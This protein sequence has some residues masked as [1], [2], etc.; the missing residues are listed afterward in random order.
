MTAE[1]LLFLHLSDIHFHRRSGKPGDLDDDLRRQLEHDAATVRKGLPGFT[2]IL[3]SGDIAYSGQQKEYEIAKAWLTKLCGTLG[4]KPE[5]V[6]TVPGNHDVDRGVVKK[7]WLIQGMHARLRTPDPTGVDREMA[8]MLSDAK[9]F[10]AL[11]EPLAEYNRFAHSYECQA[12]VG[13][14]LQWDSDL[15]LNDGSVLRLRGANS[16]LISGSGEDDAGNRLVVGTQQS[17]PPASAG[18]THLLLCHHPP[19][20]LWE[21]DQFEDNLKARVAVA[22]FGH[23]HVQRVTKVD[24]SLRVFSGAVQ[25]SRGESGWSPRYNFLALTVDGTGS[26]RTLR[27]DLMPR[28][29]HDQHKEFRADRGRDGHDTVTYSLNL[30]AWAPVAVGPPKAD[31]TGP[32]PED[33]RVMNPE[34]RLTFRFFDLPYSSRM[35]VVQ[36]LGLIEDED[37]GVREADRY[38]RYFERAHERNLLAQLWQEVESRQADGRPDENPFTQPK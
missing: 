21:R 14:Q 22:L 11:H 13:G 18:V 23:K 2:G 30:P 24:N 28:V 25:P 10:E 19:D 8:D 6:W 32:R 36:K 9:A 34:R 4:C 33:G 1:S 3:V 17:L 31:L 12:G 37:E 16:A 26:G 35:D 15:P 29:W 20:W 27:V 7:S 38:K 5:D